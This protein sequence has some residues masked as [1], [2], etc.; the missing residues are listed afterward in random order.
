MKKIL[1]LG[2]HIV[3]VYYKKVAVKSNRKSIKVYSRILS[4]DE[5]N[6]LSNDFIDFLNKN[7]CIEV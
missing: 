6:R 7:N 1:K 5:V 2:E 3:L 4:D